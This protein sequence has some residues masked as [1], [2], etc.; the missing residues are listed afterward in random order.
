MKLEVTVCNVCADKNRPTV[1]YR[2]TRLVVGGDGPPVV[3]DLCSEHA[4]PIESLMSSA[5]SLPVARRATKRTAAKAGA[6]KASRG[7]TP[8]LTRAEIEALRGK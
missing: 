5:E 3:V 6:K 7:R 8:V 1:Q 2:L 4:A